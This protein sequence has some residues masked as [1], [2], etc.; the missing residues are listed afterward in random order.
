MFVQGG[1]G[2]QPLPDVSARYIEGRGYVP[3][4]D[5]GDHEKRGFFDSIKNEV[6]KALQG[7]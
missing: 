6:S 7:T 1:T 3:S 2:D 4:I 5:L